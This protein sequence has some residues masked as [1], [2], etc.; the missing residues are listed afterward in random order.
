MRETEQN[1]RDEGPGEEPQS[2]ASGALLGEA[3]ELVILHN[4]DA[5]RLRITR[6]DKLILTK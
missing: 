4:G 3:R 2:V 5:Y 1:Q 6:N